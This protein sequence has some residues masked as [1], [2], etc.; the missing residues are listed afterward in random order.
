M[1]DQTG[2]PG[3]P[4]CPECG[5]RL[6]A[7]ETCADLF[8]RM[9]A[10]EW[11]MIG[12]IGHG[13]TPEAFLATEAGAAGTKAHFLAVGSYQLQHPERL[14]AAALTGLHEGLRD[15]LAGRR[16]VAD[17]R[18]AARR[19]FNGAQRVRRRTGES[20]DP[21]LGPWPSAWPVTVADCC[22]VDPDDYI[23]AVRRLAEAT[24]AAIDAVSPAVPSPPRSHPPA[25]RRR[26][27]DRGRR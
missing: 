1:A 5:A 6:R 21:R 7:G 16:Q 20:R 3:Q 27:A 24:V 2:P 13:I 17:V 23:D 9:L 22:D 15:V 14:S 11:E 26:R 4:L 12:R 18:L 25:P 19:A 8:N 10:V